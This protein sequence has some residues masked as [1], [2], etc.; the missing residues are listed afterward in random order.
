VSERSKASERRGGSRQRFV[1]TISERL[2]VRDGDD[3][4]AANL[5]PP[6]WKGSALLVSWSSRK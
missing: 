5:A 1:A 4:D 3:A 6:S 2:A